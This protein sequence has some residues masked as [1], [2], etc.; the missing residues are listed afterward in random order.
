M[1]N[2]GEA[3]AGKKNGGEAPAGKKNGREAPAGKKSGKKRA[4]AP[5]LLVCWS[6]WHLASYT[7]VFG[8][9]LG[10]GG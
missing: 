4:R 7:L 3:P 5:H 1:R 2:G 9:D 8:I 10:V 6:T